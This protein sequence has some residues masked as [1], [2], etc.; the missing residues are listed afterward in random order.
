MY[1]VTSI[2]AVIALIMV[3][4]GIHE[5][6]HF[7]TARLF[8]I[9]IDEFSIGFPPRIWRRRRNGTLYSIGALPL[10]GYVR[11]LGENGDSEDPRSFGAKPAWQ[12][13][14][15][16]CAGAFMNFIG[17]LTL[18][19][20]VFTV[21]PIPEHPALIE[22]IQP[23][24]P[25]VGHFQPGDL[26]TAIDGTPISSWDDLQRLVPCHA[27]SPTTFSVKRH[28]HRLLITV[29]PRLHPPPKQGRVGIFNKVTDSR[30][31]GATA[32]RRTLQQPGDFL[33]SIGALFHPPACAPPEGVTGPVGIAR[34]T[35]DAANS[36]NTLGMGPVLDLTAY[37][38]LNLAFVNLL[39][40]PALDG[41]RLLFVIL[42]AARR[43]RI[44]P[45]REALIHL[46]GFAILLLFIL[47]V[48]GHDIAQWLD[49]GS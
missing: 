5:L 31:D 30:S 38:S 7:A 2:L 47:A 6:G 49:G 11:M 28:S 10:G 26:V 4:V 9:Q 43:R 17:A 32:L 12:R 41:G 34:A 23:H 45:Q 14:I 40:F 37:I 16:L 42:G 27:G 33:G 21:A 46:A 36:A 22:S 44:D 19:F 18:F 13:A 3:L 39:P 20:L 29:T 35:G 1:I 15:V 25:A 24:S 48:S 8:G